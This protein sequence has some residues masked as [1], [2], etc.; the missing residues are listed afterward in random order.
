VKIEELSRLIS[1]LGRVVSQEFSMR[2]FNIITLLL[3]IVGGLNWLLV[4]LSALWQIVAFF[5][6]LSTSETRAEANLR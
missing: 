3:I 6:S 4:G 5:R 1:G 2:V